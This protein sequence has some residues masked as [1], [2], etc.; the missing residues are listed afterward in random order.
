VI[1]K[2]LLE[3]CELLVA[4]FFSGGKLFAQLDLGGFSFLGEVHPFLSNLLVVRLDL[5][6]DLLAFV[7]PPLFSCCL[8]LAELIFSSILFLGDVL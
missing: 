7:V 8:A 1:L 6:E 3:P 5:V 2:T 4:S